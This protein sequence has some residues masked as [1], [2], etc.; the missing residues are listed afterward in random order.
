MS[1][2]E[3][4]IATV[5]IRPRNRRGLRSV[6]EMRW[7][8]SGVFLVVASSF[9]A[10]CGSTRPSRY[11]QLALP[12]DRRAKSATSTFPVRLV[13][14]RFIA[15]HLYREDR[16]V[17]SSRGEEIGTYEYQRWAEPPTEMIEEALLR[18]LRAS[19]HYQGVY[20]LGSETRGDFVLRGHLFD[21]KEVSGEILLAR[22]TLE[23]E[24]REMKSGQT[25]WG[26]YYTHD[27]PVSAKDISAVVAALNRNV[28]RAVKEVCDGLDE[29]FGSRPAK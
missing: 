22:V 19:G 7:R 1:H 14:G 25:V 4:P 13:L 18:E 16:I 8:A 15:S 24:L 21:F 23:L 12:V 9:A 2:V 6:S 5:K 29:Y 3:P 17:Y 11:Y 10:G 28:Q 27:E 26:H 20:S